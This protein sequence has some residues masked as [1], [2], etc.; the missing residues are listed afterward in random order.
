MADPALSFGHGMEPTIFWVVKTR[1]FIRPSIPMSDWNRSEML[2]S[3]RYKKKRVQTKGK[4]RRTGYMDMLPCKRR[5]F[6]V[7]GENYLAT[8]A[9]NG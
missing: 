7:V 1:G 9:S 5:M 6:F 4:K 2:C 8:G 3:Y